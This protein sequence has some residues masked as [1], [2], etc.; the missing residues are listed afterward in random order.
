[1]DEWPVSPEHLPS[2]PNNYPFV[3]LRNEGHQGYLA[4]PL[5]G[6]Q[7]TLLVGSMEETKAEQLAHL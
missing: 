5:L 7:E 6:I 1:L 3:Q 2:L 4:Q